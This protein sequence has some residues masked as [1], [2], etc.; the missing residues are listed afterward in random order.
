MTRIALPLIALAVASPVHAGGY[1]PPIL[2]LPP[3]ASI[4][5]PTAPAFDPWVLVPVGMIGLALLLDGDGSHH[6]D[7]PPVIE[8]LP[9]EPAPVP[10]PAAAGLLAAGLGLLGWKRRRSAWTLWTGGP[11]PVARGVRV[12]LVLRDGTEIENE[13]A[14]DRSWD[15]FNDHDDITRYRV[16]KE[17]AL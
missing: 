12:D 1:V 2:D 10:L 9:E 8:P 13:P 6:A 4:A 15:H 5:P 17:D 14:G 3:V 16:R 11:C 7:L